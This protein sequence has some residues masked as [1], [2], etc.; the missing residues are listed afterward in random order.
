MKEETGNGIF[1]Q[2]VYLLE[3]FLELNQLLS[4][5]KKNFFLYSF[6]WGLFLNYIQLKI[7]KPE[8]ITFARKM[9]PFIMCS[10]HKL[11]KS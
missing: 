6:F 2:P 5:V 3:K 1:N 7:T 10:K 9:E 4:V 11:S 8:K